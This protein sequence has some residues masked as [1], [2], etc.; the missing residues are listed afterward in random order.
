L[1]GNFHLAEKQLDESDAQKSLIYF[2]VVAITFSPD[3]Y[4]LM[5]KVSKVVFG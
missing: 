5:N 2:C 4:K 3:G 1:T